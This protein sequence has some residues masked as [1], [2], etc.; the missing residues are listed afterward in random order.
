MRKWKECEEL[1]GIICKCTKIAEIVERKNITLLVSVKVEGTVQVFSTW[2]CTVFSHDC[3]YF[4]QKK[5][6]STIRQARTP[7]QCPA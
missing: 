3:F 1:G 5:S 7:A 6:T 2:F 4:G